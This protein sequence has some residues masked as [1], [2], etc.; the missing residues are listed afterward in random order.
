ML[1]GVTNIELLPAWTSPDVRARLASGL[2]RAQV[3]RS[4][5]A[6]WTVGPDFVHPFLSQRLAAP[7]GFLCV[8]I[9]LPTDIDQLASL[10]RKGADVRLYC[11]EITTYRDDHLK[12]PPY[13]VHSKM[14][15]FW[16][17]DRT[18]ELWVGSHNWTRR[19]LIGLNVET[20]IV[21]KMK[22]SSALFVAA[23]EYL[24]EIKKIGTPFDL[25]RVAYYKQLQ[26]DLAEPT[27]PFIEIEASDP[28]TLEGSTITVFGSNPAELK[29]VGALRN[30]YLS[31]FD[32]YG[33]G[34]FVYSAQVL[35]SG[36]MPHFASGASGISFDSR[37]YAFRVGS[38]LPTLSPV[39]IV[40]EDALNNASYFVVI[41]VGAFRPDV[42]ALDPPLRL[43]PWETVPASVSP[44][45]S[46]LDQ[47]EISLLFRGS[48]P[49]V[50][51]PAQYEQGAPQAA[52]LDAR[53][54]LPEHRLIVRR[55]VRRR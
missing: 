49:V 51:E 27:K 2:T 11:E 6:Y 20:S 13:L 14:L 7:N 8:D 17:P 31:A 1:D 22:D 15:L 40:D 9:H 35:Q 34:E 4:A 48:P 45:L 28:A 52:I 25:S 54:A 19:A 38:K 50:R 33:T 37:R 29:Q 26:K 12:E 30:V 23:V 44:L 32:K 10:V 43:D 41:E 46:R 21:I 39:Q 5:V 3:L 36:A 18:A 53:R 24:D 42:L 55:I 16:L 47:Q